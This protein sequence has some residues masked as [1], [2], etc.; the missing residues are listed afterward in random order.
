KNTGTRCDEPCHP[1]VDVHWR[2]PP[3]D[4]LYP[5]YEAPT[6]NLSKQMVSTCL[7]M[8]CV[9]EPQHGFGVHRIFPYEDDDDDGDGDGPNNCNC[10]LNRELYQHNPAME[11][12][13]RM[14]EQTIKAHQTVLDLTS[15]ETAQE[16]GNFSFDL[17]PHWSRVPMAAMAQNPFFEF[18]PTVEEPDSNQG[19]RL[20]RDT[21]ADGPLFGLEAG[22]RIA[23]L[24]CERKLK[25]W[26]VYGDKRP[27]EALRYHKPL[28]AREVTERINQFRPIIRRTMHWYA[29]WDSQTM[30]AMLFIE[31][32]L[33]HVAE[34]LAHD[35]G[36]MLYRALR[37][38]HWFIDRLS[39]VKH[40]D[41]PDPGVRGVDGIQRPPF[42]PPYVD[43]LFWFIFR[44]MNIFDL[45]HYQEGFKF[46]LRD[47]Y[48]ME[49]ALPWPGWLEPESY[50]QRTQR[51]QDYKDEF[52]RREN[53]MVNKARYV[54]ALTVKY[55]PGKK[56]HG[57]TLCH[58][59]INWG[60]PGAQI[61]APCKEKTGY[62]G[63]LPDFGDVTFERKPE[64]GAGPMGDWDCR[65]C[66]R[67]FDIHNPDAQLPI[68]WPAETIRCHGKHGT[69]VVGS[70]CL[71]S[72][73]QGVGDQWDKRPM[74][75]LCFQAL[76]CCD[77]Q[78]LRNPGVRLGLDWFSKDLWYHYT[79]QGGNEYHIGQVQVG[80]APAG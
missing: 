28:S 55:I 13:W 33:E 67:K 23:Q 54:D 34:I 36:L 63:T 70:A 35:S 8:V 3:S 19:Q 21:D 74:C 68:E 71:K 72:F 80:Q 18:L 50:Q 15:F 75:P 7:D 45:R 25:D 20:E 9:Q 16:S 44:N 58:R 30:P 32:I 65:L 12:R 38:L 31:P 46:R 26:G 29:D 61:C 79:G 43:L 14:N 39:E 6:L 56:T 69:M 77:E 17:R 11:M 57:C 41:L 49:M 10:T 73:L 22:V 47:G 24:R 48:D 60:H 53:L 27:V 66:Y 5:Y 64:Q 1:E 51:F 59:L 62:E 42:E 37:I 40:F 4:P 2:S 76:C 52:W 78:V